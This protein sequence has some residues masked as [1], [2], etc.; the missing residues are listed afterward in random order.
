MNDHEAGGAGN[1]R[2]RHP[3]VVNSHFSPHKTGQILPHKPVKVKGLECLNNVL[4]LMY[5][6]VRVQSLCITAK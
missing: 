2:N 5:F 3:E 6:R 1:T 4:G